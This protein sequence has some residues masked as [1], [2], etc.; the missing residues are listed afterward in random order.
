MRPM[1]SNIRN[2]HQRIGAHPF[3]AVFTKELHV[4]IP[5]LSINTAKT[6]LPRQRSQLFDV[7]R[8]AV[9]VLAFGAM[10]IANAAAPSA[11]CAI[12]NGQVVQVNNPGFEDPFQALGGCPNITGAVANGWDDNTCW[13]T[14]APHIRYARDPVNPRSGSTSQRITLRSGS[15]VQFA[16][17]L[18][19]PLE[20]DH[21]YSVSLWMRGA[22]PMHVSV[23]LRELDSPYRVFASKLVKLRQRW[24]EYVFDAHAENVNAVLLVTATQPGSI[25]VDDA[26]IC[27]YPAASPIA[28]PPTAAVPREYFGMHTNRLDTPWPAVGDAIGM[29]RIWDAGGNLDGSGVGAQWVDI[30]PVEGSYDWSGLDARVDAALAR[31]AGVIYT[32]GGRTPQWASARPNEPTPYG[33]GQAAEPRTARIWRD[34]VRAITTRYQGKIKYWE[35]WNEPDLD[36]FYTGTPDKLVSLGQLVYQVAKSVDPTNVVLAPGFSGFPGTGYLDYYLSRGGGKFADVIA[37]H[38]YIGAPEESSTWRTATIRAVMQRH[39]QG[40]KPLWN[41]EQGWVESPNPVP[42]PPERSKGYIARSHLL[43]WAAGMRS[44]SYY[45]WDN[46]YNQIVFTAADRSTLTPGG[47]AYREIA[48]WMTGAVMESVTIDNAG[49]Y[50]ATLRYP[51]TH[52]GRAIW[53]PAG[54]RAFAIPPTWG[55]TTVRDLEGGSRMLDGS[56]GLTIGE[57]PLLV[58]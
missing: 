47:K 57:A 16:Q 17:Y 39:G 42:F 38:A 51:D 49:T 11:A 41:S 18:S 15:R 24:T 34:W 54:S 10:A 44:F 40:S 30:N 1:L 53:N 7:A 25:W 31:G 3:A 5:R 20:R 46:D 43:N 52:R 37:Y 33:P 28:T 48:L 9:F 27:R 58:E 14:A 13:D 22:A 36:S 35:V 21:K 19:A 23:V 26:S 2:I 32:L 55:A 29:V 56:P 8:S 4:S 45:T 6:T 50:V 12:P